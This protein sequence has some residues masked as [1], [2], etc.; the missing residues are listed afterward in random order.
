MA[1][2][3]VVSEEEIPKLLNDLS[4]NTITLIEGEKYVEA[5]EFLSQSEQLLEAVTTQG[6]IVDNDVVLATLHNSAAAY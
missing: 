2:E 1:E 6:G 3:T 4:A 5:L